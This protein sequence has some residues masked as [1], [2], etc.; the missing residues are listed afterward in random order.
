[1]KPHPPPPLRHFWVTFQ[2]CTRAAN[3]PLG[4]P[5]YWLLKRVIHD[6]LPQGVTFFSQWYIGYSATYIYYLTLRHHHHLYYT[7]TYITT[8][9]HSQQKS[10]R[11]PLAWRYLL[12]SNGVHDGCGEGG[13]EQVHYAP[14]TNHVH[15]RTL[16]PHTPHHPRP[17]PCRQVHLGSDEFSLIAELRPT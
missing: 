15:W 10:T 1:M 7:T 17:P 3:Y 13:T 2:A 8:A 14:G 6:R 9:H 5:A 4:V 11:P 16:G 12:L